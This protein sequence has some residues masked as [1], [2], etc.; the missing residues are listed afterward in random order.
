VLDVGRRRRTIPA[1]L[2][3][4]LRLRDRG[5]RF[6]GCANRLVDGHH[7]VPWSRGGRTALENLCLLCRRHHRYVHELGFRME[8]D[9]RG[10]FRFF[11]RDGIEVEVVSAPPTPGPDPIGVLRSEHRAIGIDID[12]RTN[13]PEWDGRRPDYHHIVSCL[14][15]RHERAGVNGRLKAFGEFSA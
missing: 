1:M 4:A 5:C 15:A 11:R 13:L 8:A 6:P 12:A 9:G 10:G 3:R 2:R 7:V 14:A